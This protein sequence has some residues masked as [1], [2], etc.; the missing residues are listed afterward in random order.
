MKRK[1]YHR[2]VVW[3][4][5]TDNRVNT[6]K[7]SPMELILWRHAEAED[8]NPDLARALT[9]KGRNQAS[10]MAAVGMYMSVVVSVAFGWIL[11]LAVTFAV[12]D[13]Q[14]VLDAVG[15]AVVYI[16]VES[17]GQT[18]AEILLFVAVVAQMF[19]L[20]ASVTSA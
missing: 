15:Q 5:Y 16:W 12:P 14:G 20:T 19:C 11:L 18:W 13:T 7:E 10:R 4:Q 6:L 17:L 1:R 8:T 3:C 2:V 9:R